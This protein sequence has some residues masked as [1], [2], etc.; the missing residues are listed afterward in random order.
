M[1]VTVIAVFA[2]D[3]DREAGGEGPPGG[4]E[5]DDSRR[6]PLIPG[7]AGSLFMDRY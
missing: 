5:V 7:Q 6:S 4:E 1:L 2:T 3:M